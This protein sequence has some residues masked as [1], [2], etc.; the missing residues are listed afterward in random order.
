MDLDDTMDKLEMIQFL[1]HHQN[2]T[3]SSP[4]FLVRK[5]K[6]FESIEYVATLLRVSFRWGKHIFFFYPNIYRNIFENF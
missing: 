5:F 6:V 4:F 2:R 1:V 3:L